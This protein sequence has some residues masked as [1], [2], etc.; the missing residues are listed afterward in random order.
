MTK[1]QDHN[2]VRS[3]MPP[4]EV[5]DR[6]PQSTIE[7]VGGVG[8]KLH[9]LERYTVLHTGGMF[10]YFKGVKYPKKG[11]P[12]PEALH[13]INI[14]KRQMMMLINTVARKEMV[15]PAVGIVVIPFKKKVALLEHTLANFNRSNDYIL[16]NVYLK[17]VYMTP[18]ARELRKFLSFFLYNLGI[19]FDT[20]RT[21]AKIF[22]TLVEYD[23][24]Y[25]YR[26]QD[27]MKEITKEEIIEYPRDAIA[28]LLKLFS[29]RDKNGEVVIK[30]FNNVGKLLSIAL[31]SRKVRK[32]FTTA[33]ESVEFKDMQM[34]EAD[35][36]HCLTRDDYNFGGKTIEYRLGIYEEEHQGN[37]PPMVEMY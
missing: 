35:M 22:S 20:S 21:T 30:K 5:F 31:L 17:E 32:A 2:E 8:M 16:A 29:E 10:L 26:I 25:R 18:C 34:D 27:L 37:Y 13:A 9:I 7:R 15:L 1:K 19:S 3:I 11:F 4:D 33:L 36:Y 24:A 6:P 12:F 14:V 23:D 28:K